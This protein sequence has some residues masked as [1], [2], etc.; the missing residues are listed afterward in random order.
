MSIELHQQWNL[1]V[2]RH[3]V[4]GRRSLLRGITAAAMATG[5]LNWVERMAVEAARLRQQNRACILLWMQG[6]PSQFETFSPKPHH[7]N[8]GETRAI[9]TSVPGIEIAENLPETAQ[10]MDDVCI[11][12]SV[13]SKEGS[14]QRASF[15]LH[16]GYLPSASVKYPTLGSLVSHQLSDPAAELPSFVRIGARG[17][18]G[19]NGGFLGVAYDPFI[20]RSADR[21]PRNVQIPTGPERYQRRLKLLNRLEQTYAE[22]EGRLDVADH[23]DLYQRTAKMITSPSM[24]VFDLD[25]ENVKIRDAY[26]NS[27]FGSGCLLAR[28][29]IE[30]GVTFVEVAINGWDTHQDNF[31]NHR[32]MCESV[33]G[34]YAQL[35]RDLKQ[36]DLLDTTLVIWMGEFGRT[37]RINGRGGRDHYPKAFNV[38][39]AGGGVHGGQVIGSTNVAGTNVSERPVSVP[40]L[41]R[42]FCSSLN[43]DP[44]HEN[45][46]AIGRP[47]RIA[48]EG[49]VVHE[50]FG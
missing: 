17:R 15:L 50:V 20:M 43:I 38:A 35:I 3:G 12:R 28:R 24:E 10:V 19:G 29:L 42:T 1:A 8:G 34:P 49:E 26:G 5:S 18:G 40:D 33:D 2:N 41:F 45:M 48:D 23:K 32:E 36:R 13:N 4:V 39:L 21:P 16:T 46:S 11:I 9:S 31:T 14:H 37:P 22:A 6:G 7:A 25:K 44:D 27:G 47:I 30:S